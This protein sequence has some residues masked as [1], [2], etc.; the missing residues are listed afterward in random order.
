MLLLCLG[1]GCPSSEDRDPPDGDDDVD[2][3]DDDDDDGPD[4][5]PLEHVPEGG[6]PSDVMF[7][8]DVVHRIELFADE[9]D[10]AA[11]Y[12][13]PYEYIPARMV[14]DEVEVGEVGLRLK[15]RW[16]SFRDLSHKAAFKIDINRF[17]PGKRLNG[18][19][20]LTLN[21]MVV[22]CSCAKETV[23]YAAFRA[24]GVPA[25]RTGYAWIELNGEAYGLY[26]HVESVDDL[27]LERHF[28]DPGGNLY[29]ANYVVWDDGSYTLVDFDPFSQ[30]FY[31]LEEGQDV[32]M[33]D[34]HAI[35]DA[36]DA[37][38]GGDAFYDELAALVDW[39]HH[40][41][42]T[43]AEQWTGHV[44]GYSLNINNYRVYFDPAIGGRARLLPWDL[45]YAFYQDW[46][47]GFSWH[48]PNG[49]LSEGCFQDM[50]C[51]QEYRLAADAACDRIDDGDLL[52]VLDDAA[53][54]IN[55]HVADDP[56]IEC[57][58]MYVEYYQGLLQNWVFGRSAEVRAAWGL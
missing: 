10:L 44:D 27:F 55:D 23:A 1:L 18:L 48:A 7:G 50:Q 3:I 13:E 37:T 6:D 54:L 15:G 11:L 30:Q 4:G 34:I 53:G 14:F 19:K 8:L 32:G 38:L 36:L 17:E 35:T 57:D 22:D 39:E 49:R 40:Q 45:D 26:L 5:P 51:E 25:P 28:D 29:E 9:G 21:N 43:A 46:E 20:K 12:P 42:L 24:A 2:L 52:Q 56:R 41:Q 47:W 33:A 31:E 16:G 58:A